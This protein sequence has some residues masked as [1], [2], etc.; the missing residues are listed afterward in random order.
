LR[1][2]PSYRM[3]VSHIWKDPTLKNLA[4]LTWHNLRGLAKIT[5]HS[6]LWVLIMLLT[7]EATLNTNNKAKFRSIRYFDQINEQP[8]ALLSPDQ[9]Q[10]RPFLPIQERG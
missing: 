2:I 1:R 4:G 10:E 6:Q 3:L 8:F 5:F 9:M 7:T